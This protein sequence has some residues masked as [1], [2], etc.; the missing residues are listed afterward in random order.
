MLLQVDLFDSLSQHPGV[1]L[2]DCDI[3]L[4][5]AFPFLF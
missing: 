4:V 1:L 5:I 3:Y 2:C